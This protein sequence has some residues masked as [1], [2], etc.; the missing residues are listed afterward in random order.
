[1]VT[2]S[3]R[4]AHLG[5]GFH[6]PEDQVPHTSQDQHRAEAPSQPGECCLG[7][8]ITRKTP[9]GEPDVVDAVGD[10][11]YRQVK[12]GRSRRRR[13]AEFNLEFGASLDYYA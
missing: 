9:H 2:D 3:M 1:M 13:T 10:G 11:G 12:V 7:E 8:S 4:A 6:R 5:L